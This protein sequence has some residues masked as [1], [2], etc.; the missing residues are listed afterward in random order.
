MAGKV[1]R[2]IAVSPVSGTVAHNNIMCADYTPLLCA[3]KYGSL[4]YPGGNCSKMYDQL[5]LWH[6]GSVAW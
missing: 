1:A 2:N 3:S 5:D 6:G 4:T